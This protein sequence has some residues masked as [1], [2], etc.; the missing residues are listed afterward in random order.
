MDKAL[1]ILLLEDSQ[2]D[3]FLIEKELKTGRI[4]FESFAV[5]SKDEFEKALYEVN[6]DII[7]ADHSLPQ[8]N[9]IEALKIYHQF[10]AETKIIIP[11]IL[12]TG[13]VSEEFAAQCIKSGVDDYILKDRLKRLPAAIR[14][15]LEKTQIERERQKFFTEII[16][17]EAMMR[18]AEQLAHFGSWQ[19]DLV[20]RKSKWSDEIY[21]I[22]GYEPKHSKITFE[23]FLNHIHPEDKPS[24]KEVI[25]EAILHQDSFPCEFRIIDQKGEIK[26][27]LSNIRVKR[28]NE[29]Q[30]IQL[31]GFNLDI[32]RQKR[33]TEALSLQ[34]KKLMEIAWIQSH[35][36]RAP[37]ARMMGLINILESHQT[38]ERHVK[39]FLKPLLESAYELDTII[40]K[41]VRKTE[42]VGIIE[43]NGNEH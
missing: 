38:D 22:L 25:D 43:K 42:E 5:D 35:E 10:H 12:I 11:F 7:L 23:I 21:R 37:L 34:N 28:N 8:F 39:D 14:S 18:E 40:R 4:A 24:I 36:V 26:H 2:E 19:V 3:I 20:N 13:S 31:S 33:Q 30:P 16:S 32:T 9:S 1:K 17:N 6:P 15:A 29:H 41:I 27:I